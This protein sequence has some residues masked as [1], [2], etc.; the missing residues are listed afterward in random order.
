MAKKTTN[1]KQKK[2]TLKGKRW[3]AFSVILALL[4]ILG[5]VFSGVFV[6]PQTKFPLTASIIDQLGADFPDPSFVSNVTSTLQNH[7]FTVSY[8]NQSLGVDFFRSLA[9]SNYGLI[10][11]R[12][13]SAL[14]SDSSTVDLFTSERYDPSSEKY[15]SELDQEL[16]TVAEFLYKPGEKYY[17]LSSLFMENLAG[18]FP[19]SI[20]IA[21]GCQSLKHGCEHMAKAF[22][23]RGAKAYIGWTDI[24]MP[25]DTD[26]ET[27]NLLTA[28]LN[29]NASVVDAVASTKPHLYRGYAS[30]DNDTII[31]VESQM[32]FYP[33]SN[34]N[35]TI[36]QLAAQ[37][38]A[39]LASMALN[40]MVV[41]FTGVIPNRPRALR[42][43][44]RNAW[45]GN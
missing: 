27:I 25:D 16:V 38:K 43:L 8:Y 18:H 21:M 15:A 17:A 13:H 32:S 33:G 1:L 24:V 22:I 42:R 29:E 40:S 30:P 28:L 11:L 7:G 3:A 35:L 37:P 12:V 44:H 31:Q 26:H 4:V 2:E 41:F 10:I 6:H 19:S 23:D 9:N 36:S 34:W 20:V 45:L 5:F 14:R 39:S